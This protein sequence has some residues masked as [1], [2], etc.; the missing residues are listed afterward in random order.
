MDFHKGKSKQM[1]SMFQGVGLKGKIFGNNC[2][3]LLIC[4]ISDI[5]HVLLL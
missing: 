3:S 5:E 2:K 4:D 1:K